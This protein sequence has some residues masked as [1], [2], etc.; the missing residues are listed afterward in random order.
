MFTVQD[1][2]EARQKVWVTW[3]VRRCFSRRLYPNSP[4]PGIHSL[5]HSLTLLSLFLPCFLTGV[6]LGIYQECE[7][8]NIGSCIYQG[9]AAWWTLSVQLD[10][11]SHVFGFDVGFR[12]CGCSLDVI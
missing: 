12:H 6:V 1:T 3:E 8:I 11:E 9:E 2:W 7:I 4:P 10:S 5:H